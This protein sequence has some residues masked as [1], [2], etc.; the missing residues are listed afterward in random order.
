MACA[1]SSRNGNLSTFGAL[2]SPA[3][4]TPASSFYY[5]GRLNRKRSR[6][7]SYWES[8][9][10]VQ[11]LVLGGNC[12]GGLDLIQA[13]GDVTFGNCTQRSFKRSR[14][15]EPATCRLRDHQMS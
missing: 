3:T 13:F 14:R 4:I 9:I 6:H 12:K 7:P 15:L 1:K 8:I 11:S 10:R 5:K 2:Q